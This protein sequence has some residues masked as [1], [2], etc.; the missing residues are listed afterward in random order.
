[1]KLTERQILILEALARFK[2]LTTNNLQ[3]IFSKKSNSYINSAIRSLKQTKYPLVK[4]LNFG[5]VP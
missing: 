1:M 2:F 4:S 5:V 3:L